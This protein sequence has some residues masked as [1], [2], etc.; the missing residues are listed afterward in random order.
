MDPTEF[1]LELTRVEDHVNSL[2]VEASRVIFESMPASTIVSQKTNNEWTEIFKKDERSRCQA[3]IYKKPDLVWNISYYTCVS[4]F[5][6]SRKSFMVLDHIAEELMSSATTDANNFFYKT[7]DYRI[8]PEDEW[9]EIF[10]DF[11]ATFQRTHDGLYFVLEPKD[12]TYNTITFRLMDCKTNPVIFSLD[13][14][15]NRKMKLGCSF[16]EAS[17]I[18][19]NLITFKKHIAR[20]K[21]RKSAKK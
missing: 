15:D 20:Y 21:F 11:V 7:M 2:R 8:L 14:A 3:R 10:T 17:S 19:V 13:D 5:L 9:N 18:Y 12:E 1:A 6:I 4:E 16:L